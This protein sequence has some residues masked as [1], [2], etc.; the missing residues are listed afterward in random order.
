MLPKL[1]MGRFEL[2]K[3]G[4]GREVL[5]KKFEESRLGKP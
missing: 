1:K 3:S 5:P 4:L 2:L